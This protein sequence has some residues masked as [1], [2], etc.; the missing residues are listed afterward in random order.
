[1]FQSSVDP[2]LYLYH[3]TKVETAR[4]CIL[5]SKS[6]KIGSFRNTNDPKETKDWIFNY[7]LGD[8]NPAFEETNI[9]GV[10]ISSE[11]KSK[12]KTLSFSKDKNFSDINPL[13]QIFSRGFAKSRMW[14]QYGG[15]HSG[16]CLIF[17]KRILDKIIAE[18]FGN[19]HNDI[20]QG[21]VHYTNRP[22]AD[23]IYKSAY[24][25][26]YPYYKKLGLSEYTRRHLFTHYPRLFFE[27]STDWQGEEEYRWVIV[28]DVEDDL[29]LQ[30]ENALVGVV[31]GESTNE[32]DI[33]QIV[34][35]VKDNGVKFE[36]MKWKNCTPWLSFRLSWA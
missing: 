4:D 18:Q 10:A 12:S 5:R 23:D 16:V 34:H 19:S 17:N 24:T 13:N 30:F 15:N 28:S 2:D 1:M 21:S 36:K 6:L 8:L 14:A 9:V 7:A 20:Y 11:I 29:Y 3:Y 27:K 22:I 35:L 26:N 31:F 32:Q 33:S 25:I